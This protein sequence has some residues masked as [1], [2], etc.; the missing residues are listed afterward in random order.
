MVIVRLPLG[1]TEYLTPSAVMST[2]LR[3]QAWVVTGGI[4]P[5]VSQGSLTLDEPLSA[6]A[7]LSPAK[8]K[9]SPPPVG[10]GGGV[11]WSLKT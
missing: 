2:P 3:D 8:T 5:V 9:A 1:P 10:G 4:L 7:S 6:R 11:G